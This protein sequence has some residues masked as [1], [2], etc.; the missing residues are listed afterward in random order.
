MET[1]QVNRQRNK[2]NQYHQ[3]QC[4]QNGYYTTL[5]MKAFDGA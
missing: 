2:T 4:E 3:Y 1:S 5:A